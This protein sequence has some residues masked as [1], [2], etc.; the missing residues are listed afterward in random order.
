MKRLGVVLSV[1]G[2]VYV[3][4]DAVLPRIAWDPVPQTTLDRLDPWG[5]IAAIVFLIVG[6]TLQWR[7]R[8]GSAATR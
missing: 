7:G 1:V 6:G 4:I 8:S 2:V 5:M 3:L